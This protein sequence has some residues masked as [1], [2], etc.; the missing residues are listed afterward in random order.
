L[1]NGVISMERIGR[2]ALE[3]LVGVILIEYKVLKNG[4]SL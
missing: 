2:T 4:S 1:E 3:R